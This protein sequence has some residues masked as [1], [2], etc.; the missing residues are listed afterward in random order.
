MG[1]EEK[2]CGYIFYFIILQLH[3]FHFL[4]WIFAFRSKAN[5]HVRKH[6]ENLKMGKK[7]AFLGLQ[8]GGCFFMFESLHKYFHP[9]RWYFLPSYMSHSKLYV[10]LKVE[11]E[12][13][14]FCETTDNLFQN[15]CAVFSPFSLSLSAQ[16]KVPFHFKKLPTR[17][18]SK[19]LWLRILC[20]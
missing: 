20:H 14:P 8:T 4:F 9:E 15:F 3:I 5:E 19:F 11:K 12:E 13:I 16:Q 17:I 2:L 10:T 1:L 6:I 18:K 7:K